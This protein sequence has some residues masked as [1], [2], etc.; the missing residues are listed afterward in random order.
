MADFEV[1]VATS[2]SIAACFM[3]IGAIVIA[4]GGDNPPRILVYDALKVEEQIK[5]YVEA[6]QIPTDVIDAAIDKAAGSGFVVIDKGVGIV[7]GQQADFVL[8]DFIEVGGEIGRVA[9][10]KPDLSVDMPVGKAPTTIP[11]TSS[12]PPTAS[13]DMPNRLDAFWNLQTVGRHDGK[14]EK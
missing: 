13:N 2:L 10:K 5:P 9:V 6:G 12:I 4:R 3:A 1:T 14:E 7:A 11:G 8:T